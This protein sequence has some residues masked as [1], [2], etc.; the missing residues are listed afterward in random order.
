MG[1]VPPQPTHYLWFLLL[2]AVGAL[3]QICL[4]KAV[5]HAELSALQPFEFLAL[6]WAAVLGFILFAEVPEIPVFEGGALI[7][8]AASY[9]VHRETMHQKAPSELP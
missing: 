8:L 7:V 4:T 9:I 1:W 2:A 6:I 5:V 3:A